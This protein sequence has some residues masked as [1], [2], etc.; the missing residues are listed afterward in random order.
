M[1]QC[2]STAILSV[3]V[4]VVVDSIDVYIHSLQMFCCN[5]T[6]WELWKTVGMLWSTYVV[7]ISPKWCGDIAYIPVNST[8]SGRRRAD[9][10]LPTSST[11]SRRRQHKSANGEKR[12]PADVHRADV[13]RRWF[14]DPPT[15]DQHQANVIPMLTVF[16]ERYFID[17]WSAVRRWFD[18]G[19]PTKCRCTTPI[20]NSCMLW[21]P[22]VSE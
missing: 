20:M 8:T 4:N 12:T 1:L 18:V 6:Y 11:S 13:D 22:F 5:G 16:S 19:M 14:A 21:D 2:I 17:I 15:L 10:V 3:Y 9:V 7:V